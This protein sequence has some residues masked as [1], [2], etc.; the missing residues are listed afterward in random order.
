MRKNIVMF[1]SLSIMILSI[2][3]VGLKSL[4]ADMPDTTDITLHKLQYTGKNQD[5]IIVNDGNILTELPEGFEPYNPV[6]NGEVKFTLVDVTEYVDIK[7]VDTVQSELISL[8]PKDYDTWISTNGSV[9]ET[10]S[11]DSLGTVKFEGVNS[12][13]TA[14]GK[15][16]YYIVFETEYPSSVVKPSQPVLVQLPMTN[17]SGN[18]YL[19][20]VHVYPKNQLG[21]RPDV[22]KNIVNSNGTVITGKPSYSIGEE[23][24]YLVDITVPSSV[25]EYV[26][27]DYTDQ[28]QTGLTFDNSQKIVLTGKDKDGKSI[29]LNE[30]VDY[31]LSD[32]TNGF[33]VDFI[34]D[35]KVSENVASL[36]DGII[37]ISYTMVINEDAKIDENIDNEYTLGWQNNPN[38]NREEEKG[39]KPVYTGGAKFI[40]ED[41]K[42]NEFLEGAEFVVRNS[43]GNYYG[44]VQNGVTVWGDITDAE[45]FTSDVNGDF[46]IKGL[47]YGIYYLEEITSPEGYALT[48]KPI[49]F[50]VSDGTY[51]TNVIHVKNYKKTLLP[52]TGSIELVSL[53]ISGIVLVFLGGLYY[54]KR[55][56]NR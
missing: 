53:F 14:E 34:I 37:Y 9:V 36:E 48:T 3:G 27:F 30:G 25:E 6:D 47:A 45:K 20:N 8:S 1:V 40:K 41:G 12:N 7:G 5:G 18:G 10:K 39:T 22:E 51:S 33:K 38:S 46:E 35:G 44:G 29:Q 31:I 52:Q 43:E 49:E 4:A 55:L 32:I 54:K 16:R 56:R 26:A 21:D 42:T 28:G 50:E 15:Y 11:V 23:V 24:N 19:E 17:D 13:L 2:V